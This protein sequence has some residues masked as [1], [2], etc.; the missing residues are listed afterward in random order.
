MAD[1][2]HNQSPLP[3]A[4]PYLID[5][6][7]IV[8]FNPPPIRNRLLIRYRDDDSLPSKYMFAYQRKHLRDLAFHPVVRA[9]REQISMVHDVRRQLEAIS[10]FVSHVFNWV[11]EVWTA[12]DMDQGLSRDLADISKHSGRPVILPDRIATQEFLIQLSSVVRDADLEKV[13]NP[14]RRFL[15]S[16]RPT[17]PDSFRSYDATLIEECL[18]SREL[19][20]PQY[21]E[22]P[23]QLLPLRPEVPSANPGDELTIRKTKRTNDLAKMPHVLPQE[24]MPLRLDNAP[25]LAK[26]VQISARDCSSTNCLMMDYSVGSVRTTTRNS[27]ARSTWSASSVTLVAIHILR[28]RRFPKGRTQSFP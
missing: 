13:I 4:I 7:A 14:V 23:I 25:R 2:D 11:T 22:E 3:I 28:T 10:L 18:K 26:P 19:D 21:R 24:F 6:G 15:L 9:L 12:A 1:I 27:V 20:E 16:A 17:I 5:L 8:A